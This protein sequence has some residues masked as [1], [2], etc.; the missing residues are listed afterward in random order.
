VPIPVERLPDW[1]MRAS[2]RLS[3]SFSLTGTKAG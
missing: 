3:L 2:G 1:L